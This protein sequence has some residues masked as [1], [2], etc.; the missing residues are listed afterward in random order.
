MNT[1]LI[2]TLLTQGGTF[3]AFTSASKD[4]T[5]TFNNDDLKFEF[6]KFALLNI[7]NIDTPVHKE[8]Y[9]QFNTIDGAIFNGLNSDNNINLAESLQN[10]ALNFETLLLE[11]DDY[12]PNIKRTVAERVFWKWLK[13][14]GAIR[15][16]TATD[17]EKS[18]MVSENRFVEEDSQNSG[19]RRYQRVVEYIGNIDVINNVEKNGHTYTE[20]YIN[21]PTKVGNTP[22]CLFNTISDDNYHETMGL[23]GFTE[24]I[25]GRNSTTIHP[26]GLSLNA[27]YDY[28]RAVIYSDP[29]ANW[30]NIGTGGTNCYFTEPDTFENPTS[31]EIVKKYEDYAPLDPGITPF[32]DIN[33]LRSRLDGITLDFDSNSYYDIATDPKLTNILEYNGDVKSKSFEFNA[34]LVYYDIYNTS[35]PTD[36]VTNLYGVI[37]L[38]NL[39][40]TVTGAYIQRLK[41][42]KPNPITKLNGNSYGLKLNIKFDTSINNVGIE[43]IIND[44]STFSMDL[45]IDASTQ[46]Q[47]AA[48]VLLES[49]SRFLDVINRVNKL[50]NLVFTNENVTELKARVNTLE[51]NIQN[52]QL[53][54]ANS[55]SLLDLIANNSDR[56]NAI[57]NGNVPIELQY[58]TDVLKS[59]NGTFI[60]KSVPN[61]IKINNTVQQYKLS[62]LYSDIN[63]STIVNESNKLDLNQNININSYIKLKEYTNY[64]RFYTEN[65]ALSDLYLFIDDSGVKFK[66]GQVVKIVWNTDFNLSN[67]NLYIYTDKAN[68][69]G[70][71]VYGTLI[72][73]ITATDFLHNRPIIELICINDT[74]Y[75]FNIDIVR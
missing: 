21:V 51:S 3:Y 37:F 49:Q 22:V 40:P 43:T 59:G 32:S 1:P 45:F 65:A 10:Y 8:N 70:N 17:T 30:A 28:D 53:A 55:T 2:R 39:T 15:F 33:Y 63:L 68:R 69:F 62:Q 31:V 25:N 12:N 4:L 5:K 14:L 58:N 74:T 13:E 34:V 60:D 48:K 71:G 42:F 66:E 23:R 67:R 50:E 64:V 75:E 11:N 46:L 36:R 9:I 29:N 26:D 56:I 35:T 7:P 73:I 52:A 38:D 27:F 19:T 16:R 61:S 47:E 41:K 57:V 18:P 20:I 6:S 24:L 72:G 54:F 44:Y